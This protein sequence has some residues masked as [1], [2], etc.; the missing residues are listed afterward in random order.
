MRVLALLPRVEHGGTRG[1]GVAID[2]GYRREIVG[3]SKERARS[4]GSQGVRIS[5]EALLGHLFEIVDGSDR[6]CV[7]GSLSFLPLVAPYREPGHDVDA[8]LSVDL[9][10]E[11]RRVVERLGTVETLR[12]SEIAVAHRMAVTR[13]L[14]LST[15]FVHVETGEGLLDLTLYRRRPGRFD[16]RLSGGFSLSLPDLVLERA[17]VLEWRGI[18]Y[19]AAPLEMALLPKAIALEQL[20]GDGSA[21]PPEVDKHALDLRHVGSLIDWEFVAR[22]GDHGV[23]RWLGRPLPGPLNRRLNP[24]APHHLKRLRRLI[25]SLARPPAGD[26]SDG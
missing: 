26:A 4:P 22:L 3:C 11:R 17:R 2:A 19:R 13:L 9:F 8:A 12:L 7:H 16:I 21:P 5:T 24:F 20:P 10:N 23:V 18:R 6:Y 1:Y 15:D 25:E 14:P